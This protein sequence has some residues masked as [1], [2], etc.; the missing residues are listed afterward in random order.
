MSSTA[1]LGSADTA[2]LAAAGVGAAFSFFLPLS[3]F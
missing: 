2:G 3:C 1:T